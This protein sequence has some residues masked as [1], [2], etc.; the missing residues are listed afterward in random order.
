MC[1][2]T[3]RR[4]GAIVVAP[5]LP[6]LT[7]NGGPCKMED[8]MNLNRTFRSLLCFGLLLVC[9]S[10]TAWA[11]STSTGTV[12]GQVTDP[13]GAV[14]PGADVT[15]LDV[16]TNTPRK[17]ITNETGRYTFTNVP[18]GIYDLSVSKT[19]FKSAKVQGQKVAVTLTL[20]IDITLEVG[21][22]SETV[23]VSAAAGAE[24][25]STNAAVGTVITGKQLELITN[26]GRD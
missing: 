26:L 20:T 14:V 18:P 23:Q 9:L 2:V 10:A 6:N 3:K 16:A 17:T 13:Q 21:A 11:Q 25:Q 7:S 5:T 8:P 19:G 22:V 15:L 1:L 4:G 12:V 24:L